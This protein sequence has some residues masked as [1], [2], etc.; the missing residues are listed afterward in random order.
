MRLPEPNQGSVKMIL[1]DCLINPGF[2]IFIS[3]FIVS[4]ALK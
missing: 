3:T 1:R 4:V 2:F